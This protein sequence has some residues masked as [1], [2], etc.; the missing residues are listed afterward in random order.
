MGFIVL[1][2]GKF[3]ESYTTYTMCLCVY[4]WVHDLCLCVYIW[5]HVLSFSHATWGSL[6]LMGP[7]VASFLTFLHPSPLGRVLACRPGPPSDRRTSGAALPLLAILHL[8]AVFG[9]LTFLGILAPC[10]PLHCWSPRLEPQPAVLWV[11]LLP[12]SVGGLW[13]QCIVEAA[14]AVW[15]T[16]TV[17]VWCLHPLLFALF[18]PNS[19]AK[20]LHAVELR[21]VQE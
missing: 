18:L 6:K 7:P 20:V 16:L 10:W 21:V 13:L 15:F 14:G 8:L 3:T 17:V 11:G 2:C 19:V 1:L 9:C 4:V 5:L 12:L